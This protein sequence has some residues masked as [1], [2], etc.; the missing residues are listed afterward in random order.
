MYSYLKNNGIVAEG[1]MFRLHGDA[2]TG[3]TPYKD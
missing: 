2:K 3:A 1:D